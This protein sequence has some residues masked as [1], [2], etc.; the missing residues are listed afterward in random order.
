MTDPDEELRARLRAA[1]P[2]AD[3]PP[4]DPAGM[5]RLLEDIMSHDK[6]TPSRPTPVAATWLVAA[7]ACLVILGVAMTAIWQPWADEPNQVASS[8]NGTPAPGADEPTEHA[9]TGEPSATDAAEP[10]V[11]RAPDAAGARCAPL[12]SDLIAYYDTAFRGRVTAVEGRR[13][14]LEVTEVYAGEPS[15]QVRVTGLVGGAVPRFGPEQA[16]PR[17]RVDQEYLIA[18]DDGTVGLCG[19]SG[20]ATKRLTAL[21]EAAF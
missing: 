6:L 17:F 3:L 13:V 18:A 8:P 21:Y 2:A 7:A 16:V 4:A 20:P 11:L 14:T 19:V 10:T 12:T 5:Q 9:P 1:D 15:G